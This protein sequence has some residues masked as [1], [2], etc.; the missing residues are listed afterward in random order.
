MLHDY[1]MLYDYV[2][3]D[4]VI[5]AVGALFGLA[6]LRHTDH[7]YK[8]ERV[9][10]TCRKQIAAKFHLCHD[11]TLAHKDAIRSLTAETD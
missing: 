11:E 1:I 4:R 2:E 7:L 6:P 10:G 9:A 3:A 8:A 5:A